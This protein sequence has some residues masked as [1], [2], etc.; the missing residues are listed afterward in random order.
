MEAGPPG[1]AIAHTPTAAVNGSRRAGASSRIGFVLIGF[2]GGR[3][4]G[5]VVAG[6][7]RSTRSSETARKIW[8]S[9]SRDGGC[10]GA[11][12]VGPDGGGLG[13]GVPGGT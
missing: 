6:R 10:V 3:D 13:G 2:F 4:G 9:A 1:V 12:C 8:S 7:A 5:R 11:G